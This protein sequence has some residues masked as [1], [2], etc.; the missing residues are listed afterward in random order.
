MRK[1]DR[2]PHLASPRTHV[3]FSAGRFCPLIVEF[4]GEDCL[5]FVHFA[6]DQCRLGEIER[7]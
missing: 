7:A 1:T 6:L 2:A 3:N 4:S 5:E